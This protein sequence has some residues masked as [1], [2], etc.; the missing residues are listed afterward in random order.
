MC[1]VGAN[2]PQSTRNAETVAAARGGSEAAW[3]RIVDIHYA[4]VLRFLWRLTGN[5]EDARDLTQDTFLIAYRRLSDLA[6]D[7]SFQAWLYQ[8]ARNEW[9]KALRRKQIVRILSLD[10]LSDTLHQ[11]MQDLT[12]RDHASAVVERDMVQT[13]LN[14]MSPSL[15]HAFVWHALLG[16]TSHELAQQEGISISAAEKRVSRAHN[17]FWARYRAVE[18]DGTR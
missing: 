18:E 6:E 16:L 13:A 14:A 10:W 8:I 4:P 9:R 17:E 12:Q 11:V 5:Q 7:R 2:E 15:R 1:I 3:S